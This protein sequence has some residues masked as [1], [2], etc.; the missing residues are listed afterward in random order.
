VPS[1]ETYRSHV[2]Q[3]CSFEYQQEMEDLQVQKVLQALQGKV[4][5]WVGLEGQE[6][7]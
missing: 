5:K 7:P 6:V 4:V 3:T 2:Y 1:L